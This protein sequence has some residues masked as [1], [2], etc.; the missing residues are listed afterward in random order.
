MPDAWRK[1]KKSNTGRL[2][3]GT[4]KCRALGVRNS[5]IP[6]AWRKQQS[7]TGHLEEQSNARG[8]EE[9]S[10]ARRFSLGGR[11]VKYQALGGRTV[12]CRM[13]GVNKSNA[14]RLEKQSNAGSL[15]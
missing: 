3:E 2:A 13:L 15:A 11:T 4:V 9:Q 14:G 8:L 10:N 12:K 7:N 1:K 6:G 5:H